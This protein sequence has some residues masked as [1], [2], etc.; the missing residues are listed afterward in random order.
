MTRE[1]ING[2]GMLSGIDHSR[3]V[4]PGDIV[5]GAYPRAGPGISPETAARAFFLLPGIYPA[6]RRL[7]PIGGRFWPFPMGSP[8]PA[9]DCFGNLAP[10]SARKPTNRRETA[11]R[12]CAGAC[13]N[14]GK[15]LIFRAFYGI[16]QA[17]YGLVSALRPS[18][19]F[20]VKPK[21][22]LLILFVFTLLMAKLKLL[23]LSF[24]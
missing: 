17:C 6:A 19:S 13:A 16:G 5:A 22:N 3:L 24:S 14:V 2:G 1:P 8:R 20:I 11:A 23:W 18:F 4:L 21:H 9:A 12:I 7:S 15:T 10:K